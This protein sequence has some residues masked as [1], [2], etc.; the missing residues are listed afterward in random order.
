MPQEIIRVTTAGDAGSAEGEATTPRFIKGEIYAFGIEYHV[1][2]PNTTTIEITEDGGLGRTLLTVAAGNTDLV[3]Y[4]MWEATDAAGDPLNPVVNIPIYID[5]LPI[6]V[7]VDNAD[8]LTD[9]VTVKIVYT[10]R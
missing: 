1:S 3:V 6:T 9:A 8:A 5:A 10:P 7:A 2:A 4:P